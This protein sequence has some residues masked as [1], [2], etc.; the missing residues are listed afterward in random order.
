M[1]TFTSLVEYEN[2]M[3]AFAWFAYLV[4][5]LYTLCVDSLLDFF[6]FVLNM[7][8]TTRIFG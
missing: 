4:I 6:L 8:T 7:N 2:L 5:H 3:S 1:T